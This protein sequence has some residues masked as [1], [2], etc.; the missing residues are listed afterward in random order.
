MVSRTALAKATIEA[1]GGGQYDIREFPPERK[2]IDV[3]DFLID[4]QRFRT[5]SGWRPR[6]G[7]TRGL[8]RS[9]EYYRSRLA[10]YI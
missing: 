4:D 9:I 8:R 1:N 3:G 7:I 10:S 5:L 2:R 6:I